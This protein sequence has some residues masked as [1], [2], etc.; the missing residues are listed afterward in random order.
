M[1]A[2]IKKYWCKSRSERVIAPITVTLRQAQCKLIFQE[3]WEGVAIGMSNIHF[4]RKE[5]KIKIL[6]CLFEV[7]EMM[8]WQS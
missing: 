4:K 6:L 2:L 7:V 3:R 5:K 1:I 8:L